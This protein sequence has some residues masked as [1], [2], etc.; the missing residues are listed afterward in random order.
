MK[1]YLKGRS[2]LVGN[3]KRTDFWLDRFPELFVAVMS[4]AAKWQK[5]LREIGTFF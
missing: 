2:L 1:L 4:K 5:W 3:R